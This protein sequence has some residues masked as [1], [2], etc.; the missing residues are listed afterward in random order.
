MSDLE[1]S[2]LTIRFEG[3]SPTIV[4]AYLM[5]AFAIT[6]EEALSMILERRPFVQYVFS[7]VHG[8]IYLPDEFSNRE[9]RTQISPAN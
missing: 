4:A 5:Y 1:F 6:P 3:R 7:K 8:L 2:V 9:D